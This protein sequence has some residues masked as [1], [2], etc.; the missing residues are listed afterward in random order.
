MKEGD[1]IR[2]KNGSW[3]I[4][5]VTNPLGNYCMGVLCNVG[6]KYY[7][8]GRTDLLRMEDFTVE[9]DPEEFARS[10]GFTVD[11]NTKEAGK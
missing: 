7:K 1:F 11:L 2:E 6:A 5:R 9:P 4:Y 8:Q 3:L 10:H